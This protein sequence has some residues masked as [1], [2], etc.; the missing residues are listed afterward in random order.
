M[1]APVWW[2]GRPLWH[3][4]PGPGNGRRLLL[5][6]ITVTLVSCAALA[7]TLRAGLPAGIAPGGHR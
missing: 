7:L 4:R 1:S 3:G 5:V 6:T 2:L